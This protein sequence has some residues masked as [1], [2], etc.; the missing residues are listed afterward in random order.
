[1]RTSKG[2]GYAQFDVI[3]FLDDACY[4][5]DVE[6]SLELLLVFVVFTIPERWLGLALY[7]LLEKGG[8]GIA[9]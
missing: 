6:A 2:V 8:V 3:D 1:M 4:S 9:Q 7:D 5:D